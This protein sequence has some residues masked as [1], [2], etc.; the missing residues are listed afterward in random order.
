LHQSTKG[1]SSSGLEVDTLKEKE[2]DVDITE[3]KLLISSESV[4]FILEEP[5][6]EEDVVDES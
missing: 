6:T 5:E 1:V 2:L 3:L 4:V